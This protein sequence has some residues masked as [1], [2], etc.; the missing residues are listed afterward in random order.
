MCR[1]LTGLSRP[2]T[3]P[4]HVGHRLVHPTRPPP[5]D[6]S[7]ESF[8]ALRRLPD[9]WRTGGQRRSW[10]RCIRAL[11]GPAV[12]PQ[13]PGGTERNNRRSGRP[14]QA[15]NGVQNVRRS[16]LAEVAP[17]RSITVAPGALPPASRLNVCNSSRALPEGLHH[18]HHRRWRAVPAGHRR[19]LAVDGRV[20]SNCGAALARGPRRTAPKA[21]G[22]SPHR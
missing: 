3:P 11:R 18:R 9:G 12:A 16:G 15:A 13:A 17:K 7:P 22:C 2:R 20:A 19:G 10:P 6:G 4:A 8:R 1:H 21:R 5:L 14:R